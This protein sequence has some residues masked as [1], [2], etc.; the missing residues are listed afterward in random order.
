[1]D[2]EIKLKVK[3]PNRPKK[4]K[5]KTKTQRKKEMMRWIVK[6]YETGDLDLSK[7]SHQIPYR[8]AVN[9]GLI[10]KEEDQ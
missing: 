5:K 10:P 3:K 6:K 2:I 8:I 9:E 7:P 1:M 4:R